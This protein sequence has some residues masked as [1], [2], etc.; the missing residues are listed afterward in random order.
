MLAPYA[1]DP[2]NRGM[3]L[4]PPAT[5]AQIIGR[6]HRHGLAISIHAIGDRANREVLDIF[7]EVIA[8]GS[9]HPPL[10]P[11]RIEHV[12]ALHPADQSRLAQMGIIASM[13]P[14]HCTDDITNAD[15]LWG[16]HAHSAYVFRN[17]LSSGA[18][19]A[20]GS[21]APVANPNPWWGIHAAVTRQRRD[22]T[23]A[24]GWHPDQRLTV[25]EAIAAY[26]L[27]PANAI[28]QQ[29]QQGRLTP[30][31]LADLIVPDTD[32]FH[33]EPSQIPHTNVLLTLIDGRIVYQ[34][35][36]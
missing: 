12:Q 7:E 1:N 27:G 14:L 35:D 33:C 21:D 25:A 9:D 36:L 16:E 11:H 10:I 34:A 18:T 17:L 5:M 20:F 23:P 32:I 28:G 22:G 19:L 3:F 4:T 13:Q 2:A 15:R 6:A 26:T 29:H 31:Y 24:G 30:G 8:T